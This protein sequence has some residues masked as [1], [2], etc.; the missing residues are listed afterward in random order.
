MAGIMVD[1]NV[2][3]RYFKGDEPFSEAIESSD[4]V[5]M[6]P[7]VFAEFIVG[8]DEKTA[9][10]KAMRRSIEDFINVP[11]VS[12]VTVTMTTATCFAKIYRFLKSKGTMIPRNDIWL[13]ASAIEYGYEIATHDEHFSYIPELRLTGCASR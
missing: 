13:A 4:S 5:V 12:V 7:V 10:G 6:H 11:L 2:L 9:A 3:I 8:L 1:T